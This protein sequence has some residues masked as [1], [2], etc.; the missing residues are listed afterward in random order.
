MTQ[1]YEDLHRL[2]IEQPEVFWAAE[3]KKLLGK[4]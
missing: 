3:A 1:K 2:S 4:R